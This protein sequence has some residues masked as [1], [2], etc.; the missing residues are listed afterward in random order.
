MD[1]KTRMI[2][3]VQKY[4]ALLKLLLIIDQILWKS[5]DLYYY[6]IRKL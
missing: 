1:L 2:L 6:L 3:E 5:I 4:I